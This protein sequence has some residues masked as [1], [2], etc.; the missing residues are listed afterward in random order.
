MS[1]SEDTV[2]CEDGEKGTAGVRTE[3]VE[4]VWAEH[5]VVD[6]GSAGRLA[7]DSR[8]VASRRPTESEV[9]LAHIMSGNDTNLY[10]TVHGGVIMKLID[11]AAAAAAARHAGAPA[12]TVSVDRMN[13]IHP[14]QVGDLLQVHAI[15]ANVGRT[16]MD[17]ITTVSAER[18]NAPGEARAIVRAFLCFVSVDA[19]GRPREVPRLEVTTAMEKERYDDAGAHRGKR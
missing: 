7:V 9:T 8:I 5:T 11:D 14:A 10:G 12:V 18:W 1:H 15:V 19:A 2:K 3:P 16:S 17:V 13:F 6:P 4:P